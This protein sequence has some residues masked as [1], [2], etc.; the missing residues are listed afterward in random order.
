MK[1]FYPKIVVRPGP[2]T[3][4]CLSQFWLDLPPILPCFLH[5]DRCSWSAANGTNSRLGVECRKMFSSIDALVKNMVLDIFQKKNEA[6]NFTLFSTAWRLKRLIFPWNKTVNKVWETWKQGCNKNIFVMFWSCFKYLN[7]NSMEDKCDLCEIT[8]WQ[9]NLYLAFIKI[10]F[11]LTESLIIL[12]HALKGLNRNFT[13]V[14]KVR[15]LCMCRKG[16]RVHDSSCIIMNAVLRL[17]LLPKR[18]TLQRK[19]RQVI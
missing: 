2:F 10:C 15:S 9:F 16:A 5:F 13:K 1:S 4:W 12:R 8:H 18:E 14:W 3:T 19:K 6:S 7:M 11:Y 17:G